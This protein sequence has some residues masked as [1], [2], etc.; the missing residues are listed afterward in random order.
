MARRPLYLLLAAA[1]LAGCGGGGGGD[2]ERE[3]EAT[4]TEASKSR[5]PDDCRRLLTDRYLEQAF[6]EPP[7]AAMG[8]CE[9]RAPEEQEG[10]PDAVAVTRIEVDGE[11]AV[12]NVTN[13]GGSFDG[14]TYTLGLVEEDGAW[15]IDEVF[16]YVDLDREKVLLEIGRD[17]FEGARTGEEARR[18]QCTLERLEQLDRAELEELL[19]GRSWKPLWELV[20]ICEL[21]SQTT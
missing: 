21:R 6:K 12:A 14:Q 4:I 16:G 7:E 3:I 20:S 1:L 13:E 2:A 15:M 17:V 10:A 11:S 9:E 5:D 19:L 8:T 18:A